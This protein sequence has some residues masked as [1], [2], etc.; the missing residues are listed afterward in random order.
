VLPYY[1]WPYSGQLNHPGIFKEV[2]R[3]RLC[4]FFARVTDRSSCTSIRRREHSARVAIRERYWSMSNLA[5]ELLRATWRSFECS[6][7]STLTAL[8]TAFW[9][10]RSLN[11]ANAILCSSVVRGFSSSKL[12]GFANPARLTERVLKK[13]SSRRIVRSAFS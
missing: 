8:R 1:G 4:V 7:R 11:E 13:R 3:R 10:K 2:A 6:S 9:T 12:V 5:R